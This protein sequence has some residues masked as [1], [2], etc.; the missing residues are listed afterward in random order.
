MVPVL[1]EIVAYQPGILHVP[2]PPVIQCD[3]TEEPELPDSH[4]RHPGGLGTLLTLHPHAHI[5]RQYH[6]NIVGAIP[7]CQG[8][9]RSPFFDVANHVLFLDWC[10]AVTDSLM[11]KN[12]FRHLRKS[13]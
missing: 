8:Q 11:V 1:E 5:R 6:V 12:I 3:E 2:L 10:T 13:A 7:D 4:I 9:V